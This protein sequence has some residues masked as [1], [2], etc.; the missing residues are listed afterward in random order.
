MD[1]GLKEIAELSLYGVDM[2]IIEKEGIAEQ[3]AV[4]ADF[5]GIAL[6]NT[7]GF[8]VEY[9]SILSE[10][11]EKEGCNIAIL[12]DFDAS[13]LV[14]AAKAPNAYRIGIDFETLDDL[15]LNVEEVEESYRPGTHLNPLKDDGEYSDVY[16]S[17][18]IDYVEGKRIE[19]N[20]VV[21]ALDD[22][23]RFWEWIIDKLREHFVNR[24]YNR[25]TEVAEY[26]EPTPLDSF[27]DHFKQVGT[28]IVKDRRE[29]VQARLSN[30]G[31][32][33]LFDKTNKVLSEKGKPVISISEYEHRLTDHTRHIIES[34]KKLQPILQ[35]VKELDDDLLLPLLRDY[36]ELYPSVNNNDELSA[37]D[38][39]NCKRCNA[40][41]KRTYKGFVVELEL[42][43]MG[44]YEPCNPL[45]CS[46]G[47]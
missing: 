16:P 8:L 31:P 18:W 25:A 30:I 11:S 19:I 44:C 12:T 24:D 46:M 3:L 40:V 32:G 45:S 7:R 41:V 21:T 6:L 35:K 15:G 17:E 43:K 29:K 5:N 23:A 13:G 1:V 14:L 38:L 10:K 42:D 4:F 22:N 39:I 37:G 36:Q 2:L 27:T 33:F 47:F 34:D 9:A 20:S 26:K 28:C